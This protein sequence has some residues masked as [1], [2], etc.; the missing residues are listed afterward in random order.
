V[1]FLCREA[2]RV[3]QELKGETSEEVVLRELG[4]L[5]ENSDPQ[6]FSSPND[7]PSDSR[8]KI[9]RERVFLSNLPLKGNVSFVDVF[10]SLCVKLFSRSWLWHKIAHMHFVKKRRGFECVLYEGY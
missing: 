2:K 7:V 8:E 9:L 6:S 10:F 3:I 4:K 1:D 5:L